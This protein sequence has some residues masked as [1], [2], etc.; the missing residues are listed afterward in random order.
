LCGD[1][2]SLGD[3]AIIADLMNL[4]EQRLSLTTQAR[5]LGLTRRD[6][7]GK[8][9]GGGTV[10]NHCA[11]ELSVHPRQFMSFAGEKVTIDKFLNQAT[12]KHNY[13]LL[14]ALRMTV[15]Y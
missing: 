15:R 11:F 8:V 12:V 6:L 3:Q 1:G 5:E 9:G 10:Q 4:G 2:F 13:K 7:L 14:F